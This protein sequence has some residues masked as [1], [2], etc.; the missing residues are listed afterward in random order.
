MSNTY[1]EKDKYNNGKD[2]KKK[3]KNSKKNKDN[4]KKDELRQYVVGGGGTTRT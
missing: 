3:D 4:D 1:K 2:Y